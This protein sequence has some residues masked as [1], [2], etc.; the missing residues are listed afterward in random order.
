MFKCLSIFLFSCIFYTN[1]A[2]WGSKGHK[3]IAEIALQNINKNVADSVKFYLDSLSLSDASVWMD[4]IRDNHSFDYLKPMHYVNIEKDKTYVKNN[5]ENIIN[6]LNTSISLLKGKI[7]KDLER[8]AKMNYHLKVICHLIGDIHQPLH[9]GYFEDKGGNKVQIRFLKKQTNLHKVWDSE[10]I[11]ASKITSQ[12]CLIQNKGIITD[13]NLYNH[14]VEVWLEESR[15]LLPGVY[16]FNSDIDE[17]YIKKNTV[18]IERQ[19]V[20]AGL[21]LAFILNQIFSNPTSK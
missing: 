2:A 12:S 6:A 1:V 19:L 15:N 17:I 18:I 13:K 21:R 3:I 9:C 7:P 14:N 5:E 10:I 20:K 16:N 4:E 11:E 8:H